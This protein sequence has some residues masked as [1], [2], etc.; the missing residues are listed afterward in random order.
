MA[1]TDE[2][3]DLF[4]YSK[5][6]EDNN[7]MFDSDELMSLFSEISRQEQDIQKAVKKEKVT[8]VVHID[9]EKRKK[10]LDWYEKVLDDIDAQKEVIEKKFVPKSISDFS[11]EIY[12]DAQLIE[13]EKGIKHGLNVDIYSDV[14]YSG[15]QM[16]EIRYGLERGLDVSHYVNVLFRERQMK[17]IRI[18]LQDGLDVTSYARL[19]YSATDMREKRRAIYMNEVYPNISEKSYDYD[20]P[21]TGIHIYVKKGLREAGIVLNKSLP[22]DFTRD[23]LFKLMK[24]YDILYGFDASSIPDNLSNLPLRVKIPIMFAQKPVEGKDGYFD[25]KFNCSDNVK[26]TINSDG[27]VN[28]FTPKDYKAIKRGDVVAVLVRATKGANGIDVMGNVIEGNIGQNPE[29]L[30]S[31]DL[32]L[33]R[34]KNMYL[35]KKDG[36]ISIRDNQVY[37]FACLEFSKDVGYM[38]GKITYDGTIRI[39]GNILGNADI[40]ATGDIIISGYVGTAR[41]TAG[42]DIV[43]GGGLNGDDEGSIVA[44]GNITA[45]FFENAFVEAQGDIDVGYVLNSDVKCK[46]KLTTKGKKSMICGGKVNAIEGIST[47]VIGSKQGVETYVS[48]GKEGNDD[49][50][51]YNGYLN[52]KRIIE[53]DLYKIREAMDSLI[54]KV[55]PLQARQNAVYIKLQ[56]GLDVKKGIKE[57]IED[58]I[59]DLEYRRKMSREVKISIGTCIY[60]NTRVCVNGNKLRMNKDN[61]SCVIS[62][63]GRKVIIE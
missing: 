52:E 57:K 3:F 12:S 29:P 11:R 60:E 19:L 7:S 61:K 40:V 49:I 42:R 22:K 9:E 30:K 15:R 48:V 5:D 44:K 24:S 47:S 4:D 23:S 32:M 2:F 53:D 34:D 8:A 62:S 16:R 56:Q 59:K 63:E 55:G 54:Q 39:N 33:S 25:F 37:I 10:S 21:E 14:K 1:K 6:S 31:D 46:G 38:D 36:Y 20:D 50:E 18:G 13:I 43:I 27:S 28:Y 51:E 35:A 58:N 41:L 26:P 45:A 17:E